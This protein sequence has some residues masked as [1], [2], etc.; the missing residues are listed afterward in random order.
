[1]ENRKWI[2]TIEYKYIGAWYPVSYGCRYGSGSDLEKVIEFDNHI[3]AEEYA[4]EFSLFNSDCPVR[5][6]CWDD[7]NRPYAKRKQWYCEV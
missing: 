1:M 3:E 2:F 4:D 7:Q 5:V 6:L